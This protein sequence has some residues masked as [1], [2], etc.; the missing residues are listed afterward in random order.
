MSDFRQNFEVM[1]VCH[2]TEALSESGMLPLSCIMH[3]GNWA[4]NITAGGSPQAGKT[5]DDVCQMFCASLLTLNRTS[6]A[7]G[8]KLEIKLGYLKLDRSPPQ[9]SQLNLRVGAN[10]ANS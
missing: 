4:P 10:Q 5:G 2:L 7:A 9:L 1:E 8:F 6:P 3:H